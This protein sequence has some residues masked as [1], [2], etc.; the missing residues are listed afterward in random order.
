LTAEQAQLSRGVKHQVEA[1][2]VVDRVEVLC[3]LLIWLGPA[4]RE[5]REQLSEEP[6]LREKIIW[7][8][9]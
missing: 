8:A 6:G 3:D 4:L 5:A 7:R 1:L 2:P 9:R